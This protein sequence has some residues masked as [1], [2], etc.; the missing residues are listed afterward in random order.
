MFTGIIQGRGTVYEK[1]P[2]GGGLVFGIEADF[3]LT[4]PA[5]G[6]SIAVNGVCLT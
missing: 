4:D 2:G 1:R 3:D 6:E 5:E